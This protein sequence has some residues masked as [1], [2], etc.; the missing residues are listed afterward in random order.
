MSE[1]SHLQGPLSQWPSLHLGHDRH[2]TAGVRKSLHNRKDWSLDEQKP[3]GSAKQDRGLRSGLR[4]QLLTESPVHLPTGVT[5]FK[6]EALSRW[7]CCSH[8]PFSIPRLNSC[9][10]TFKTPLGCFRC[11]VFLRPRSCDSGLGPNHVHLGKSK[12]LHVI[13]PPWFREDSCVSQSL[14][15]GA[16]ISESGEPALSTHSPLDAVQSTPRVL[17]HAF[18]TA[19][20]GRSGLYYRVEVSD[21]PKDAS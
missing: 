4:W 12:H 8:F 17:T 21:L 2:W 11:L 14:P 13:C 6:R 5:A 15:K 3:R 9:L 18:F 7:L 1:V 10:W 20:W 16:L 19:R